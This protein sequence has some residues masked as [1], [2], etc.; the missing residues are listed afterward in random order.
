M[1]DDQGP[2]VFDMPHAR[3]TLTPIGPGIEIEVWPKAGQS[4]YAVVDPTVAI[5]IAKRLV[6]MAAGQLA[7]VRLAAAAAAGAEEAVRAAGKDGP[8][9]LQGGV[10]AIAQDAS[11]AVDAASDPD[12]GAAADEVE[13][14]RPAN[15]VDLASRRRPS[16]S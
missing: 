14:V 12:E 7:A 16:A 9:T 13:E 10:A 6:E 2:K 8:V 11:D 3:V 4:A 5:L 1:T 15:I